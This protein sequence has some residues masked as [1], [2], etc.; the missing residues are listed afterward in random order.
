MFFA[1]K[2]LY[3]D[4]Q[5]LREKLKNELN[6]KEKFEESDKKS[7][8]VAKEAEDLRK[9]MQEIQKELSDRNDK[10]LQKEKEIDRMKA[11][12]KIL[13]EQCLEMDRQAEQFKN[14]YQGLGAIKQKLTLEKD[15]TL[16]EVQKLTNEVQSLRDQLQAAIT[17]KDETLK[18]LEIREAQYKDFA[19]AEKERIS[20]LE[21]ALEEQYRKNQELEERIALQEDRLY[22]SEDTIAQL[23]EK[24]SNL[25]EELYAIKEE[26]A[27]HITA[28][29]ELKEQNQKLSIAFDD[30]LEKQ[31]EYQ[32]RVDS[33]HNELEVKEEEMNRERIANQ[34]TISQQLKLIDFL[35]KRIEVL[36][37]QKKVKKRW[38]VIKV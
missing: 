19:R 28:V 12:Y 24:V 37:K 17:E 16:T 5:A 10:I 20:M 22:G 34:E 4:S 18:R 30:S 38:I 23:D 29:A 35:Q 2:Y 3:F 13:K 27:K 26:A 11:S 33:L 9:Q 36:E 1:L 8:R 31:E 25:E 21:E 6:W 14:K 32:T 15:S 7:N